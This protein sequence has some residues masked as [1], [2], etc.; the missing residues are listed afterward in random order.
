[1]Q[2]KLGSVGVIEGSDCIHHLKRSSQG[3][4]RVVFVRD[5]RTE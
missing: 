4:L 5:R 2:T 1:M 3:A